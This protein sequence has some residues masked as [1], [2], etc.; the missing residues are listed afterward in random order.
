MTRRD[1]MTGDSIAAWAGPGVFVAA[2]TSAL[3]SSSRRR[4]CVQRAIFFCRLKI[5]CR[6]RIQDVV[7][8]ACTRSEE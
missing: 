7:S 1:D 4:V 2:S 3:C 8:Y 6:E 5:F